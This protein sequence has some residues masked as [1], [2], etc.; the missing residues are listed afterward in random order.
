MLKKVLVIRFRR[1][2]DSVLATALCRSLKESFPGVEVHFVLNASIAPLYD[3]HPDIDRVIAFSEAEQ[4]GT[5]YL[6]KVW[7]TV[8]DVHYDAIID[9]RSTPKTLPFCLFSPSTPYRIGRRKAYTVG[10]HNY[11][12]ADPA[13][14]D[15]VQTNLNLLTPLSREGQLRLNPA[16]RLTVTDAERV[17][18]RRRMEARGVDFARPVVLCAVT[19]RLEHKVWP[20]DRMTRLLRRL[21]DTYDAQLV[22]NY[23]G[24]VEAAA[25]RSIYEQL[26]RDARV[27]LDV[28]A[29]GLRELCALTVNADL[30]FGNEGGPRHIA[31]ALGTPT[32]ALFPPGV[33]KWFWLP[34]H[35]DRHLGLSPD[36]YL[37]PE[38]QR[39]L[40][41]AQRF[42]LIPEADVWAE[43]VRMMDT[44]VVKK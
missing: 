19:A 22:F 4:H 37:S 20:Y 3:G 1:V 38:A 41:Y 30:F 42:D 7:H 15:R 31:H 13:G 34:G 17:E 14:V 26:G 29:R 25:A 11:R 9:M 6:R 39:G 43:L 16:F 10:V 28:E 21:I 44:Y 27:F 40:T 36:D 23:A 35:D 8:R 32:L 33:E 18:F 12:L 5:A 24:D 2:G